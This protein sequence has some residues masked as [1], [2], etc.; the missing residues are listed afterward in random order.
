LAVALLRRDALLKGMAVAVVVC[1]P[2]TLAANVVHD[3]RP[4]S[5]LLP[6]LFLAVAV[7][8]GVAGF[9][10]GRAAR[11]AP[12]SNGAVAALSG[13]VVL[14]V[15]SILVRVVG[16][17]PLHLGRLVGSGLIAYA[18]GLAGAAVATRT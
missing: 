9:V 17:E 13:F 2:L 7:G 14:A 16:D 3:D 10:G 15:I 4:D 6:I 18:A 1:L 8:F 5:T 12:F 11:D